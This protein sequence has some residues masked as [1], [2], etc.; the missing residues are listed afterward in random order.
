MTPVPVISAQAPPSSTPPTQPPVPKREVR[1][2]L[3]ANPGQLRL[4]FDPRPD[5]A[6]SGFW[7][8]HGELDKYLRRLLPKLQTA[9]LDGIQGAIEQLGQ[10]PEPLANYLLVKHAWPDGMGPQEPAP[11]PDH[12]TPVEVHDFHWE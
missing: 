1:I 11:A 6:F 10:Q 2:W 4:E 12:D 9:E 7:V 8:K 3:S 5:G